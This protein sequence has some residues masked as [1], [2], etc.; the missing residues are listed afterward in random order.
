MAG[1][2]RTLYR[3][4]VMAM[5]A[6]CAVSMAFLRVW[7]E[8]GLALNYL[9]TFYLLSAMVASVVL[10]IRCT[11]GK[12]TM[13]KAER[14]FSTGV[15]LI[16]LSLF[17]SVVCSH[18]LAMGSSRML[19]VLCVTVGTVNSI[20]INMLFFLYQKETLPDCRVQRVTE[21]L[22]WG[23]SIVY[24][25]LLVVNLFS[26][27]LLPFDKRDMRDFPREMAG[28]AASVVGYVG[29]LACVLSAKVPL[30][31]RLILASYAAMPLVWI[32]MRLVDF[33]L[34]FT[35]SKLVTY[36]A[37]YV[38]SAYIVYFNVI[39]EER[40]ELE[41]RRLREIELERTLAEREREQTQLHTEL[42]LSQIEPH[43]LFNSLS[44]ISSLCRMEK[45]MGAKTALDHF[46]DYLRHNLDSVGRESMIPFAKEMEHVK[47]YLWLEQMRMGADLRIEYDISYAG[48]SIPSLVVQPLV[49]NA[50][51]H[52]I[53]PKR[54][55][56][57]V[58]IRSERVENGAAVVVE[59]DGV[60]FDPE[61]VRSTE[62]SHIGIENVRMRLD[63]LCGG[64]LNIASVPGQGTT[65]TIVIERS[66]K[67]EN[68][69]RG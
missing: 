58:R 43:F 41:R 52:G 60:G 42:M 8:K 15:A 5:L 33:F 23:I 66:D 20:G 21:K 67:N 17:A 51:T 31:K 1:R 38:V 37:F 26:G 25:L 69:D 55:G 63:A 57:T 53:F 62:R 6:M 28:I 64:K 29:Y 40:E 10:F 32:G 46:S 19:R 56:G 54:G 16:F 44:S 14:L 50:V 45:A 49:E 65:A 7:S 2:E 13:T 11:G 59:D 9:D 35:L 4:A 22:L 61:T 39:L 30:K 3:L 48:F 18:F 47:T 12:L 36:H 68:S 27:H 24:C 34:G